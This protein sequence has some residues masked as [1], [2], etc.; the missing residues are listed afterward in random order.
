MMNLRLRTT[1]TLWI[2]VMFCSS[3]LSTSHKYPIKKILQK[4]D[5]MFPGRLPADPN[6]TQTR[7]EVGLMQVALVK[8]MTLNQTSVDKTLKP[9][10]CGFP[11]Y[12]PNPAEF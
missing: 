5:P 1:C 8:Q 12:K 3:V 6:L 10:R 4:T 11:F 7:I 9:A 2:L